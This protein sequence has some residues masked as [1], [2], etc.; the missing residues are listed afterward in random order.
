MI[1]MDKQKDNFTGISCLLVRGQGL[2]QKFYVCFEVGKKVILI[3]WIFINRVFFIIDT[4]NFEL[5]RSINSSL[6]S[7]SRGFFF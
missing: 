7:L 3:F 1:F 5:S 6:R 2:K 4:L